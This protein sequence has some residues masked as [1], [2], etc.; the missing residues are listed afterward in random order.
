[1]HSCFALHLGLRTSF[2]VVDLEGAWA[3]AWLSSQLS[4]SRVQA[5]KGPQVPKLPGRAA[6]PPPLVMTVFR[7]LAAAPSF[8]HR[9]VLSGF[10]T[11]VKLCLEFPGDFRR[12]QP[13]ASACH[14]NSW[15]PNGTRISSRIYLWPL[16][17][18]IRPTDTL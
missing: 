6:T 9:R 5:I 4:H 2:P 3:K 13:P 12:H 1:M 10:P 17:P 14:M 8:R 16:Q 7:Q 15:A 18:P 11:D